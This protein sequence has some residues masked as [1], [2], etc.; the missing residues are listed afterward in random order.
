MCPYNDKHS[1]TSSKVRKEVLRSLE[2][3][4]FEELN[5]DSSHIIIVKKQEGSDNKKP[6]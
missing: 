6:L 5:K 3:W 4:E 1:G 2:L